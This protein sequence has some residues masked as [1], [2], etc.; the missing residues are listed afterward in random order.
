MLPT[1]RRR[2]SQML[3]AL[4]CA[5]VLS[6]MPAPMVAEDAFASIVKI[7]ESTVIT[8]V[9][10]PTVTMAVFESALA[11]AVQVSTRSDAPIHPFIEHSILRL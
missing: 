3:V 4:L 11:I 1:L 8:A 2:P 9:V 7:E 6:R 10:S 5:L